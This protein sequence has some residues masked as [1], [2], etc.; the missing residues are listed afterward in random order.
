VAKGTWLLTKRVYPIAGSN[1]AG[2]ATLHLTP[3]TPPVII[4][5]RDRAPIENNA[6]GVRPVL[7]TGSAGFN[8][9]VLDHLTFIE[10][11]RTNEQD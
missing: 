10:I 11:E 9:R 4:E 3:L 6:R 5:G 2:V 1:P 8:S 7:G